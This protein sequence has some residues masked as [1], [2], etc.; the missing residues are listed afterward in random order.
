[1]HAYKLDL[2]SHIFDTEKAL[3][4][5]RRFSLDAP[6][7]MCAMTLRNAGVQCFVTNT[8]SASML[9]MID[10]S[11]GL[12]VHNS[13]YAV[14]IEILQQ[15]ETAQPDYRDADHEMIAYAQKLNAW[16]SKTIPNWSIFVIALFF[17]SLILASMF[18]NISMW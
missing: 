4:A 18:A 10:N 11:I 8:M 12:Y 17:V 14:A 15:A 6:A 9:P 7:Q 2:D 3:V 5:L 13:E 16:R 1:M